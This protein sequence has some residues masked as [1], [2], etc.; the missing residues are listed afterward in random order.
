MAFRLIFLLLS[1]SFAVHAEN[2]PDP[3]RPPISLDS[4][5]TVIVQPIGPAL[6]AIRTSNG[7]RS[8]TISGHEVTSGSKVGEAVVMRI[9][10]DR[11]VLRGPGGIETLKLFPD[12]EKRPVVVINTD[13]H[14][15]QKIRV[16]KPHKKV[17]RKEAE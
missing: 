14:P 5:A 3:T 10:E 1:A 7:R 6:Q 11:V 8:A 13:A 4:S 16:I 2:L 12:V 9:D 17:K 15:H